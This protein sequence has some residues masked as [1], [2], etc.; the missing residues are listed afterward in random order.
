[1]LRTDGCWVD[2]SIF[3]RSEPGV[4]SQ[5]RCRMD[6]SKSCICRST[7]ERYTSELSPGSLDLT[8]L[9]PIH[10][11]RRES[12]QRPPSLTPR[13]PLHQP[14]R[15]PREPSRQLNGPLQSITPPHD[16]P[17]GLD[18]AGSREFP[19]DEWAEGGVLFP[20]EYGWG[21][22]EAEAEVGG[23]GFPEGWGGGEEVEG[24][25]D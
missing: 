10:H 12:D 24:V 17:R 9:D 4:S 13:Q 5:M 25:V 1:L 7:S 20:C 8:S 23:G 14:L 21:G 16:L 6:A 22:C 11:L 19:E 2:S 18:V 3:I 15:L